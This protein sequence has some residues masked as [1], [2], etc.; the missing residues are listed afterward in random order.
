MPIYHVGTDVEDA[1]GS[2]TWE[3]EAESKEHALE[4]FNSGEGDIVIEDVEVT[5]L[6]TPEL[7][8]VYEVEE[9]ELT[10]DNNYVIAKKIYE[11][12]LNE[13]PNCDI[14]FS[15]WVDKHTGDVHA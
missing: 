12:Y 2:Q 3:I 4:L 5:R 15:T 8:D 13:N 6:S 14:A 1:N 10:H 9:S 11:E 7:S